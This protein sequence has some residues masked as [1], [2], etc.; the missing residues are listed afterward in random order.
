MTLRMIPV[1]SE[2]SPK[3]SAMVRAFQ[4]FCD[5]ALPHKPWCPSEK[6]IRETAREMAEGSWPRKE[7]SRALLAY[8][9]ELGAPGPALEG[10]ALLGREGTLA[11]VAGQQPLPFGGPLYVLYKAWTAV[12]LAGRARSIL[13][14][15]V[16]PLFWN[17]SEDHDLE[18]ISA[19]GFPGPRGERILFRAPLEAWKGAPA[20][21]IPGD[22][23]WREAVFSF[24]GRFPGLAG[25]G[26]PEAELLPLEG[27]GWSRWVSRILSRL[28]GPSGLVVMEPELLR[29]PA[30]PLV[31]RAL[32][33]WRRIADLLE[34]SWREKRE[35]LGGE[36]S[37]PPLQ[38]PPLFL[39]KGGMRRRILADGDRF[40]LKGT[41][42][43]YS[44]GE[45]LALLEERPGTFSSHGA[46]RPVLQN[47][48]LPT[49]AHVVGPGEAAYLGE[50]FRFHRSPLGAGRRMPLL[51]PRLSATFLDEFSRKTLDRFG[52][53]PEHLFLAGP[54]LVRTGLPG[55]ERA[56]RVGDLRKRVLQ[57]LA[58]L[59]REA[60]RL[61]PTLSAPFRRT[62]D[63]VGRLL[64]KLEAKVAGAEAA[65]RG[66]GP[67]RLERLSR[68]VRP[69]G[70]PQERAFA[71][72]PFLP[73]L[74]G[75]SLAR[76][77]RELDVLDFR[78]RL[79]WA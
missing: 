36:R 76:V 23:K 34:E 2:P 53:D 46:L 51:W 20:S 21:S 8:Q 14:V 62:G 12:A 24:L 27:E 65:A 49:L 16:V 57:D 63:Q 26:S 66:F 72:F 31:A 5:G 39:E 13:G 6:G 10:A 70:L 45:L 28:L 61:E 7:V 38:G 64:E 44:L 73:Y 47:A 67:A 77:P 59:G 43:V 30:A 37:F 9:E 68:W 50:L 56:A 54:E 71:F 18:E 74:G 11:V 32:E 22:R 4:G 25:E 75:E 60:V 3:V 69:G 52:L 55:G 19:V 15:P 33:E 35:S 40:R 58:A 42:E 41:D 79:L 29:R 78:H 17:A 48:L 1:E